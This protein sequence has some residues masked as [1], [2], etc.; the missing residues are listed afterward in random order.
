MMNQPVDV[1]IILDATCSNQSACYALVNKANDL[2]NDLHMHNQ[3]ADF[4]YGAVV[5]RDPVDWTPLPYNDAEIERQINEYQARLKE[6]RKQKLILNMLWDNE[7]EEL[8]EEYK[9]HIDTI[10]YPY[11][12]NVAINFDE[13]INRIINPSY[14]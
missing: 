9:R 14:M 5:F 11:N 2:A 3:Q 4:K 13:N 8:K 10:A 6:E 7:L 12:Q 1:C